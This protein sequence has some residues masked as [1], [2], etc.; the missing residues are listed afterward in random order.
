MMLKRI[1]S[2]VCM[3]ASII[4]MATP[5]GVAMTFLID[6]DPDVYQTNYFSYFSDIPWGGGA[7]FSPIATA[8]MSIIVLGLLLIEIKKDTISI[9]KALIPVCI[10]AAILLW[11]MSSSFVIVLLGVIP[12]CVIAIG[13]S[14][15]IRLVAKGLLLCCIG[16]SIISWLVFKSFTFVA[17]AV[18]VLHAVTFILQICPKK[19]T[20]TDD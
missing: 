11:L 3:L 14:T 10:V 1:S 8:L 15:N 20:S 19:E 2:I 13:I 18:T 6:V 7:D 12:L 16:A 5:Y 4:L 9:G 17:L